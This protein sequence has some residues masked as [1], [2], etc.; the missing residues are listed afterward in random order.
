MKAV[1]DSVRAHITHSAVFFSRAGQ[2]NAGL[3]PARIAQLKK[4]GPASIVQ[5]TKYQSLNDPG[6]TVDVD[7]GSGGAY[8]QA[9]KIGENYERSSL[10]YVVG[11]YKDAG[12]EGAEI[13]TNVSMATQTDTMHAYPERLGIGTLMVAETMRYLSKQ[14]IA[15]F[16]PDQMQSEG[17][18]MMRQLI[19]GTDLSAKQMA[20]LIADTDHGGGQV[21]SS[22]C[23]GGLFSC[24]Q[25]FSKSGEDE[26]L[27]NQQPNVKTYPAIRVDY[28]A[29]AQ[30]LSQKVIGKFK[31]IG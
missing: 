31:V 16:Q 25:C 23:C 27:L 21:S 4:S 22:G 12:G 8:A 30:T 13:R 15:I 28:A 17:G 10:E 1:A 24:F 11:R 26:A 5:L 9:I 2:T 3:G 6:V 29:T 19:T 7:A 14:N 20:Q 18:K